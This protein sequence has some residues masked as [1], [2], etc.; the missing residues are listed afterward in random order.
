MNNFEFDDF[1][2]MQQ[3][4]VNMVRQNYTLQKVT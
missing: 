3:T 4:E 1:C 2:Q